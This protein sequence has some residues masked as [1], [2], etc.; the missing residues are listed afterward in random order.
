MSLLTIIQ[1]TC[2]LLTLPVPT[3]AITSQDKQVAQLVAL[4]NEEGDDLA[5]SYN[6]QALTVEQLFTTTPTVNQTPA[7]PADLDR[8]LPDSFFNRTTRRIVTGPITPQQWQALQAWP[9]LSTVYLCWRERQGDFLVKPTPPAGQ[10]VAYEYVSK[11]WAKDISGNPLPQFQSDSDTSYLDERLMGLG[12]RWRFLKAKGLDYAED[13][14]TYEQNKQ[15]TQGRDGGAK[16]LSMT[17]ESIN[18]D[19]V[20]MPDSFPVI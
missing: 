2:A 5:S 4:A 20:N 7:I 12:L 1:R 18:M 15:Q 14:R 6:W 13:F 19:R 3:V 10:V 9:Y 8:F 17:P 16:M 11:N